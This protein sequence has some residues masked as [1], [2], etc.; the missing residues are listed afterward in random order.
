MQE[1]MRTV[2]TSVGILTTRA[3]THGF[4]LSPVL[5]SREFWFTLL[6]ENRGLQFLDRL[7]RK[8][9]VLVPFEVGYFNKFPEEL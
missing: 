2:S 5:Q 7:S 6:K 4:H 8:I 3:I 9:Y 1:T